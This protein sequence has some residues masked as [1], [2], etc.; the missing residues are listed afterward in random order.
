MSQILTPALMV[1]I[2]LGI[3]CKAND[4]SDVVAGDLNYSNMAG[5]KGGK[6]NG[7][8][9]ASQEPKTP[10]WAVGARLN[11]TNL[12]IT[13]KKNLVGKTLIQKNAKVGTFNF[14]DEQDIER[15]TYK[16]VHTSKGLPGSEVLPSVVE[17]LALGSGPKGASIYTRQRI[18]LNDPRIH[19]TKD[20]NKLL[21]DQ[22]YEAI[23]PPLPAFGQHQPTHVGG[24]AQR[25]RVT[26]QQSTHY[27]F[28]KPDSS[29][30]FEDDGPSSMAAPVGAPMGVVGAGG[31]GAPPKAKRAS[32]PKA[33]PAVKGTE[34]AA[35]LRR[36][37]KSWWNLFG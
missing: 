22:P 5:P 24:G 2:A 31:A 10:S 15:F 26:L 33:P 14:F 28:K 1:L 8:M 6:Q 20:I 4:D 3:A 30:F 29:N 21:D 36:P 27:P 7:S 9:K 16:D 11:N 34:V 23:P 17:P 25:G 32:A 18:P 12:G 13:A 19:T 37:K 35:S